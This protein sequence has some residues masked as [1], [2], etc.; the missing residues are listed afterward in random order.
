MLHLS[1]HQLLNVWNELDDA[2]YG[3][4][5]FGSDT[6]EIYAYAISE[7]NPSATH[8]GKTYARDQALEAAK[9]MREILELFAEM[10]QCSI[11]VDGSPFLSK[12]G[13]TITK[14]SHFF[15]DDTA[16][17]DHRIHIRIVKT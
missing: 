16:Q 4:N 14:T 10:R 8:L 13:D 6:A 17:F 2:Y 5:G 15:W 1:T 7:E 3:K 12:I 11:L 9:T